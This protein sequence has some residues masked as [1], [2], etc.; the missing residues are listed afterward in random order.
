MNLQRQS[1]DTNQNIKR[2]VYCQYGQYSLT[3]RALALRQRETISLVLPPAPQCIKGLWRHEVGVNIGTIIRFK[4]G[5]F[6][7]NSYFPIFISQSL[8]PSHFKLATSYSLQSNPIFTPIE[9]HLLFHSHLPNTNT[10]TLPIILFAHRYFYIHHKR[11]I[12]DICVYLHSH[13][14]YLL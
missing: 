5:L 6:L 9:P 3:F 7:L 2:S 10:N 11:S 8:S 14:P 13:I 12:H 4:F 1:R